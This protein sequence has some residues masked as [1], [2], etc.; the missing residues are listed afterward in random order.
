M[1]RY[2]FELNNGLY[3]LAVK[4][5]MSKYDLLVLLLQTVKFLLNNFKCSQRIKEHIRSEKKLVLYIDKMSRL[6][7]VLPDKIFSFQFPFII[8][9][10]VEDECRLSIVYSYDFKIDSVVSSSL[11]N[12]FE[13]ESILTDYLKDLQ[14]KII[15][16]LFENEWENLVDYEMLSEIV[17]Y[18]VLF[19]PGYLR[20][21]Y[22][23]E[24]VNGRIHPEHHLDF[25]FSSNNSLKI[26]LNN[27]IDLSWMLDFMDVT[28]D[29]KYIH[30]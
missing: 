22:D 20:Y 17:E 19:E 14:C 6:V 8:K 7:F 24:R 18:L 30:R 21:D 5:I 12:V 2:E 10:D 25:F 11:I 15:E 9:T 23:I 4:P 13:K 1:K 26:G 28:T 3:E 29:C 27:S 16:L